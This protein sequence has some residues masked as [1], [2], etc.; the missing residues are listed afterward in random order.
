MKISL[1]LKFMSGLSVIILL[2]GIALN[3]L[4]RQVFQS[5]LENSI[6]TSMADLM[7]NTR[8]YIRY[9]IGISGKALDE[10]G[11]DAQA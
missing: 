11:L 6:K 8:E 4:I 7:K 2:S 3:L 10:E 5:S 1:K 9:R